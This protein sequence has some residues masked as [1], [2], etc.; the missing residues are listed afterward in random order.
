MGLSIR[1]VQKVI[2]SVLHDLM[3]IE[4][5]KLPG[6]T[7]ANYMLLEARYVAQIQVADELSKTF[8]EIDPQLNTL[9]SD[10]TTKKGHGY[11]TYDINKADGTIYNDGT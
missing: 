9:H 1:N 6:R 3:G 10:G 4:A 11:M 5:V 8:C 7:F 2:K